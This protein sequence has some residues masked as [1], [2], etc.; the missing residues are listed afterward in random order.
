MRNQLPVKGLDGI[1]LA[2]DSADT[3]TRVKTVLLPPIWTGHADFTA[4]FS[5]MAITLLSL[6]GNMES[7][8]PCDT[9]NPARDAPERAESG[10]P[11]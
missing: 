4:C 1:R 10:K 11:P 8:P 9:M 6:D 5:D 3:S 2:D 7:R